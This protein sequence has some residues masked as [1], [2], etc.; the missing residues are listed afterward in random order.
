MGMHAGIVSYGGSPF[1]PEPFPIQPA[2]IG[3]HIPNVL[4]VNPYHAD[5]LAI[6][7]K[8]ANHHR[9]SEPCPFCLRNELDA[10]KAAI[11]DKAKPAD[12]I[13]K[14]RAIVRKMLGAL[15]DIQKVTASPRLAELIAEG[16]KALTLTPT[17]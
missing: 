14:L 13:E 6:C 7:E 15:V 9:L 11:G 1:Q 10:L 4:P 8:C 17:K 3:P 5:T 16:D 12:E 2:P